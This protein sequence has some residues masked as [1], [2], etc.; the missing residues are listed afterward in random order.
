MAF[1]LQLKLKQHTPLLH[2]QHDQ[3]GATLRATEIKPK[4]DEFILLT[5]GRKAVH[6]EYFADADDADK[7]A[8]DYKLRISAEKSEEYVVASAIPRGVREDL[9]RARQKYLSD[10]P[11]FADNP[12]IKEGK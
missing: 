8:L 1:S 9:D 12:L 11:Y 6:P 5:K 7:N 10:A 4:L 2:F 3:E